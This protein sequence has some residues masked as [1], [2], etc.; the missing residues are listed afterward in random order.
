[1]TR[2]PSHDTLA[3]M[4][5]DIRQLVDP[6]HIAVRG[7]V[8]THPPLLDQLRVAAI[9]GNTRQGAERRRVPDSRPP[10]RLDSV[11]A[12]SEIYVELAGWHAKLR[13]PSPPEFVYG[14]EHIS[15]R[16]ILLQRGKVDR[17]PLCP[18]ASIERTDW[19][20]VALRQLVGAAGEI[21]PAIADWLCADVT[22]WWH[23]AAV[24]TGWQPYQLRVLR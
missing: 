22:S 16:R 15:C 23:T 11:D 10:A 14:C 2:A 19:H 13:L 7:R 8:V 17:G 3:H 5:D 6:I 20:K 1:M 18:W 9:P 24:H 12:L 4:A 21:A